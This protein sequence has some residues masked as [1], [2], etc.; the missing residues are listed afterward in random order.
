MPNQPRMPRT[1]D[2]LPP[3]DS[4]GEMYYPLKDSRGYAHY[5]KDSALS[6]TARRG[7]C[8]FSQD[9]LWYYQLFTTLARYTHAQLH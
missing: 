2:S 7:G 8:F 1:R 5:K 4:D 9:N 6:Q 3:V